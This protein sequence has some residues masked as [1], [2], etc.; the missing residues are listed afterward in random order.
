MR[1][2]AS[3]LGIVIRKC[4]YCLNVMKQI[5]YDPCFTSYGL[6]IFVTYFVAE[7]ACEEGW[8]V[9]KAEFD[10]L[11]VHY[12]FTN[13]DKSQYD[14]NIVYETMHATQNTRHCQ[15]RM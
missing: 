12:Q 3:A 15:R 4:A 9:E 6:P 13:C 1:G 11:F 8:V 10:D 14:N 2:N 7:C 5:P